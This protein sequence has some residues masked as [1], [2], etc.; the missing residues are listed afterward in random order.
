MATV[1]VR[2]RRA[3]WLSTTDGRLTVA[4]L[5]ILLFCLV[6]GVLGFEHAEKLLLRSEAQEVAAHVASTVEKGVPNIRHILSAREP[7]EAEVRRLTEIVA[8]SNVVGIRMIGPEGEIVFEA[9]S[10]VGKRYLGSKH[11]A[12]L[13]ASG[14]TPTWV[15]RESRRADTVKQAG[16]ASRQSGDLAGGDV[17]L[18]NAMISDVGNIEFDAVGCGPS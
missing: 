13:L 18:P 4:L 2:S 11:Y 6:V 12:T 7:T 10:I 16:D 3:S 5:A 17:D 8:I 9:E 1:P 14:E 15:A